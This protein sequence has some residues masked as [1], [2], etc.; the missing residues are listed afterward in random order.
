VHYA[1]TLGVHRGCGTARSNGLVLLILLTPLAHGSP[2]ASEREKKVA[3]DTL[4]DRER[5]V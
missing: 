2:D 3:T 1:D 4:R 5:E